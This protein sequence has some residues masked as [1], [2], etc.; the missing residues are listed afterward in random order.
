MGLHAA[1]DSHFAVTLPSHLQRLHREQTETPQSPF[2]PQMKIWRV[3][4]AGAA[5]F[6]RASCARDDT[7]GALRKFGMNP[8]EEEKVFWAGEVNELLTTLE[9]ASQRPAYVRILKNAFGV[10][11]MGRPNEHGSCAAPGLSG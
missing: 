9:V 2:P 10:C 8:T 3:A 5:D 1:K 6:D 11:E 4:R 7:T